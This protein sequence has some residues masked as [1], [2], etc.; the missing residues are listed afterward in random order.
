MRTAIASTVIAISA[1]TLAAAPGQAAYLECRVEQGEGAQQFNYTTNEA[2]STL[3]ETIPSTGRTKTVGANY[4]STDI[5]ASWRTAG[6]LGQVSINRQTGRF[7]RNLAT[8]SW[9]GTCVVAEP[10]KQLF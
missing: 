10:V 4:S 9:S 6:F 5:Y 1:F 8:A 7:Q 2:Q 3:T